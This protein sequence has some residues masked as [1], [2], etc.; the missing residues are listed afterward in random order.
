MQFAALGG[1]PTVSDKTVQDAWLI[2]ALANK[3]ETSSN[4]P[5]LKVKQEYLKDLVDGRGTKTERPTGDGNF[6]GL[7]N[8]VRE[9]GALQTAW[10]GKASE[11]KNAI[12]AATNRLANA[13]TKFGTKDAGFYHDML[14]GVASNTDAKVIHDALVKLYGNLI[15]EL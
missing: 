3:W 2:K 12:K 8:V 10:N 9:A 1:A 15:L 13:G 4:I 6:M 7:R 11:Q 14:N 5:Q